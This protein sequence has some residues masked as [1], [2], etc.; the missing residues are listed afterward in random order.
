MVGLVK[1]D[2]DEGKRTERENHE[3]KQKIYNPSIPKF[4]I[5]TTMRTARV[6]GEAP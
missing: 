4:G 2:N 5:I 1:G 6:S 3:R